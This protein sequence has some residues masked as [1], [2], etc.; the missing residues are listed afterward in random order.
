VRWT[1]NALVNGLREWEMKKHFFVGGDMSINES[2]KYA[3]KG[4]GG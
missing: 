2:V 1:A 3:F 4:R